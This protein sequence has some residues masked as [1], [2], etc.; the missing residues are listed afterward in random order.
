MRSRYEEVANFYYSVREGWERV[1]QKV[2][3]F[4]VLPANPCRTL[5]NL[6]VHGTNGY[7]QKAQESLKNKNIAYSR[8]RERNEEGDVARKNRRGEKWRA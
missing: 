7:L 4:G 2:K 8:F 5:K 1:T 6:N 3:R